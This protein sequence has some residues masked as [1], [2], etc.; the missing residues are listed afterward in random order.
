MTK[1]LLA[2]LLSLCVVTATA[3]VADNACGAGGI[4]LSH[5]TKASG[6]GNVDYKCVQPVCWDQRFDYYANVSSEI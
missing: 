6:A 2:A 4:D 1:S 5:L 3:E